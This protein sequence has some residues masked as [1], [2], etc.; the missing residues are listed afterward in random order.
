MNYRMYGAGRVFEQ[1][2]FEQAEFLSRQSLIVQAADIWCQSII[3]RKY[4][5]SEETAGRV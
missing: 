4:A 3:E 2:V 1:A 5:A